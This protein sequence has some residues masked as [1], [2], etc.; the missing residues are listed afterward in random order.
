MGIMSATPPVWSGAVDRTAHAIPSDP[1]FDVVRERGRLVRLCARITGSADVAEDLAQEALIEAL[2]SREQLRDPSALPAWLNGIARNV[3]LRWLRRR[4]RE[5]PRLPLPPEGSDESPAETVAGAVRFDVELERRDLVDLLDRALGLLPPETRAALVLR[6]VEEQPHAEIAGRLALSEGAVA[7]RL[8]RGR[9]A[10]RRLLTGELRAEAAEW[11]IVPDGDEGAWTDT[12]IWCPS[13]AARRLQARS[14]DAGAELWLRCPDCH[15]PHGII[16]WHNH[17]DGLPAG[18]RGSTTHGA[19][20]AAILDESHR[21][22]AAALAGNPVC[23]RC[24]AGLAVRVGPRP[25]L[26]PPFRDQPAVTLTCTGCGHRSDGGV[27]GLLLAAPEGRRF[28]AAHRRVRA[29]PEQIVTV[30]G[31]PAYRTALASATTSARLELFVDQETLT[32]LRITGW[33]VGR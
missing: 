7:M 2:R 22:Y 13:C 10:L 14:T 3:C 19:L 4:G 32:R 30:D 21:R 33:G 29:E 20:F 24:G 12:N 8:Q 28:W 6:Y 18:A 26:P 23:W 1:V 25:H 31:R 16:G 5:A 11:G 17:L 9:L 27:G 15:R